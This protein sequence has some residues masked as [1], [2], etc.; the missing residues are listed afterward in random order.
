MSAK[1]MRGKSVDMSRLMAQNSTKIALGNANM[2]ARG[3]V[4]QNGVVVQSREEIARAYHSSNPKAV[5]QVAIK[6][7]KDEV[8]VSPVEALENL[9]NQLPAPPKTSKPSRTNR[10]ITDSD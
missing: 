6:N 10:K 2:N 4:L 8:F 5:R 1:S 7:I 3:D 9:K